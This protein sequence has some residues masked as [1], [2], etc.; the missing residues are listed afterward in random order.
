MGY[1]SSARRYGLLDAVVR[2]GD[3]GQVAGDVAEV[4]HFQLLDIGFQS[5]E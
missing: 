2:G 1:P 5:G 3:I 4:A